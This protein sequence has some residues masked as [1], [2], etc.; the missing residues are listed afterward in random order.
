MLIDMPIQ[1]II[2]E[3][4]GI[5]LVGKNGERIKILLIEQERKLLKE[6]LDE[7]V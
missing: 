5:T 7:S 3:Y 4:D 6:R 2:N 1:D